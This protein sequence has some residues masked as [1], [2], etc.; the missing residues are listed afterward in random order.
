MKNKNLTLVIICT[1]FLVIQSQA[2]APNWIWA[3][4]IGATSNESASSITTDATGNV[5][6]TG[7]YY[8]PSITLGSTTL[9]NSGIYDIYLVKYDG[10]GNV[11]W[12]TKAGSPDMELAKSIAVDATGNV[13]IAGYFQ[14]ATLTID[15][16]ILTSSGGND[17]FVA[18]YDSSG[19]VL[20]AKNA[21]GTLNDEAYCMDVDASGNIYLAGNFRSPAITFGTTTLTH[22][23][24]GDIFVMKYDAAGNALWAISAGK[25]FNEQARSMTIDGSGNVLVTGYYTDSLSFGV[26]MLTSAGIN[27]AFVVKL[28]GNGNEMWAKSA[29][30]PAL[31]VG[32]SIATDA[33]GNVLVAGLYEST[34]LTLG[35]TN[36]TNAGLGDIFVAKYDGNGNLIWARRVG[37]NFN[38]DAA[39]IVTDATGNIV[40]TGTYY[41]NTLVFGAITIN[42]AG[43]AD[44]LTL[45]YDS[46]GNPLW[47]ITTGGPSTEVAV[48]MDIDAN[49]NTLIIGQYASGS[50]G[51]GATT[52]TNAGSTDVFVAKLAGIPTAV[53]EIET[54]TNLDVFPNPASNRISVH[55]SL[56]AIQHIR[57]YNLLGMCVLDRKPEASNE[58][59]V[60]VS[61]LSSGVYYVTVNAGDEF[62]SKKLIVQ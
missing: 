1:A 13:I 9:P 53:P 5:L 14:G 12:A 10:N 50:L 18:K 54:A 44:I 58:E 49:G 42:N 19:N 17:L 26:T 41:S 31:D 28:D 20:W 48:D 15:T 27:D 52:L 60:D 32:R 61:G 33:N 25:S 8:S 38:E 45:K 30:G 24:N 2:Q 39:G 59:Q 56:T 21:G 7:T 35:T 62:Y 57:I 22:A 4:G 43:S 3:Y 34:T 51:F 55:A 29:G 36:L 23:G 16:I 11:L 6:A 47:A 46:A 37:A 40:V